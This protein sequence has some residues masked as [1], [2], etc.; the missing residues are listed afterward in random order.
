MSDHVHT[1]ACTRHYGACEHYGKQCKA[2]G[3][4]DGDPIASSRVF[5]ALLAGHDGAHSADGF[6]NREITWGAE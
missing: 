1:S 5:C 3:P 4:A 2:P 6:A